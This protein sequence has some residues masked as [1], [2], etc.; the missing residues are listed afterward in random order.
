MLCYVKLFTT[1]YKYF[2][3]LFELY[4]IGEAV[5]AN[6]IYHYT[7]LR[8]LLNIIPTNTLVASPQRGRLYFTRD[9]SRQFVPG[10]FLSDSLGLRMDAD[11]LKRTFGKKLHPQ[12]QMSTDWP[13]DVFGSNWFLNPQE[14]EELMRVKAGGTPSGL[15]IK[16]E[17]PQDVLAGRVSAVKR[18]ES[19][20]VLEVKELPNL[21]KYVTG[22]V[23]AISGGKIPT[24]RKSA[25][26]VTEKL[27]ET[28]TWFFGKGQQGRAI[29]DTIF[30]WMKEH[31]IPFVFQGRDVPWE[32]ARA[33]MIKIFQDEKQE[34]EHP[35]SQGWLV[36][37][38]RN[39][40]IVKQY[41]ISGSSAERAVQKIK[42][43]K[44]WD[45]DPSLEFTAEPL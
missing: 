36:K 31:D 5:G 39:G 43:E 19:E 23:I 9:Y 17:R 41:V 18:W 22:L 15:L 7:S 28:L 42:K 37:I 12:G 1:H 11:L 10:S 4:D 25:G 30:A 27:A 3:K 29:R 24:G 13:K 40:A 6:T 14:R 45:D 33:A 38:K 26:D 34:R 2:M 44:G 32:Q 20:E 21:M 16:G 35:L 8:R